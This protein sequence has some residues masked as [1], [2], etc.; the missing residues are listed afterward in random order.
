MLTSILSHF[1]FA[2]C[3]VDFFSNYLVGRST[4]YSWN[5]FLSGACD[6]DVGVGQGS[7]LS[8][9]FSALYIAPL[10]CIFEDR[11][12]ALNLNTCILS[13]VD[14]GLLISQGKT[15]NKILPELYSS[16]KVVT[17]LM[18]MFGL[19]M[20]HDKSEIF[21]FSRAHNDSN[22][23]LDLS[24]MG[25]PTLKPKTYWRYLG[26]YFDQCLFFKEHVWYYST[27]A[28][29]TVKAMGMLGKLTG[30]LFPLQ[31]HLL[32]CFC[33][34]PITTYSFRLWFF[35]RAPTKAQVSLLAAMQR[36]AALWILGVFST[37]PTG[38]IEALADLIPIHLHLKKLVKQSCLRAATLPSQYALM[39]LL[40]AKHFKGTPPHPQFLALLNDIQYACLKGP[41]LDTEA[42][43]LNLTECFDLLHVEATPGC[44]LLDSFPDR[45]SF[46]PC[47]RSSLRDCKTHLQ[48]LDQL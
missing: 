47:N 28:L 8:P 45:I 26:F 16:Y 2:N 48:S 29:S 22:P 40:S 46:H 6:A 14:D 43:L 15:Y 39:S 32:Y 13:F 20:E 10:L 1:G 5:L 34:V 12:Q 30:G 21:H 17:D 37:S 23:E 44:R 33:V 19:V 9:I 38:G 27:K 35:A 24:D 25:A 42:S 7:A 31:K 3:I 18:V 41:L 4:Q 36:K 11:A